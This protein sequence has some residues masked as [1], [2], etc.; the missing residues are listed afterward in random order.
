MDILPGIQE[1]DW[2]PDR[3]C[4]PDRELSSWVSSDP[5]G[6]AKWFTERANSVRVSLLEKAIRA[7]NLPADNF[8]YK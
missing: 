2:D 6:Y 7:E 8:R 1:F 3:L 4:V 5:R